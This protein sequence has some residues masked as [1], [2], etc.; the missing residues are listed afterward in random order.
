MSQPSNVDEAYDS[1]NKHLKEDFNRKDVEEKPFRQNKKDLA[2]AIIEL[3]LQKGVK[4][5][6]K[7]KLSR[8]KLEDLNKILY[9]VESAPNLN[10]Q[11]W[12]NNVE[13]Q[14][15]QAEQ[16]DDAVSRNP[17]KKEITYGKLLYIGQKN[18]YKSIA[19]NYDIPALIN[20]LEGFEDEL[21]DCYADLIKEWMPM[22][23]KDAVVS[24]TMNFLFLNGLVLASAVASSIGK[25]EPVVNSKKQEGPRYLE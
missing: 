18:A 14:L 10:E 2:N 20:S 1:L 23:G 22:D 7:S 8:R 16:Y 12:T 25:P 6:S 13:S 19:K 21:T 15:E 3:A 9:E 24:P 11:M 5:E 4:V 17:N